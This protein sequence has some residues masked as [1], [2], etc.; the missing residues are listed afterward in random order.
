MLALVGERDRPGGGREQPA[1]GVGP[2]EEGDG[3][4][5]EMVGEDALLLGAEAGEAMEVEMVHRDAAGQAAREG[6]RGARHPAG[7][8]EGARRAAHERRLA[9][10]H[11]ALQQNDVTGVQTRG[12]RRADLLGL[13]RRVAEEAPREGERQRTRTRARRPAPVSRSPA[14]N[15]A[16]RPGSPPLRGSAE[17]EDEAELVVGGAVVG[18]V[19]VAGGDAVVELEVVVP[20]DVV[21]EDVVPEDVVPEDVVPEDVVPEVPEEPDEP[22]VPEGVPGEPGVVPE[23]FPVPPPWGCANGSWYW[24]SPALCASA[25]ATGEPRARTRARAEAMAVERRMIAQGRSDSGGGQKFPRQALQPEMPI[26]RALQRLL[27]TLLVLGAL[28][29]ITP[30]PAIAGGAPAARRP[31]STATPFL[32]ARALRLG[33]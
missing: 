9:R 7:D 8:S 19:T 6:E 1:R 13:L 2:L 11:L 28:A 17:T 3:V 15:I 5:G 24:S 16:T 22:E 23:P 21:P 30:A 26:P 25:G 31:A 4:G 18:G 32:A 29:T 33:G 10:S 27:P 14:P 20:E 12:Q